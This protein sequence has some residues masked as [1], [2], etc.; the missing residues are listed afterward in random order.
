GGGWGW[1]GGRFK[2]NII[3]Q[4]GRLLVD[5]VIEP[6][7]M[8]PIEQTCLLLDFVRQGSS[9]SNAPQRADEQDGAD[10]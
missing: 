3:K 7:L 5:N 2:G 9:G 6:S 8:L 4:I 10:D 1:R